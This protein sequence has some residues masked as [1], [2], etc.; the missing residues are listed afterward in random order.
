MMTIIIGGGEVIPIQ[1]IGVHDCETAKM[2]TN[3]VLLYA[4]ANADD[5]W[6]RHEGGYAVIRG[7]QPIPD[8]PGASKLFD[9]LAAVYPVLWP[10]GR[11]L[12]HDKHL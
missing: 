6:Y 9:A 2:T 11:G 3:E 4:L 8:L 12:F 1:Y 10:Y 5:D 7:L